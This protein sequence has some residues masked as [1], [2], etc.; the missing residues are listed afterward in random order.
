VGVMRSGSAT[1]KVPAPL[2]QIPLLVRP[3][4]ILVMGPFI[5]YSGDRA[6]PL[7]V[8]VY[9]GRSGEFVLYDDDGESRD[10]EGGA[11]EEITFSW[12]DER[13]VLTIGERQ[14]QGWEGMLESR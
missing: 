11:F 7:E 5:Q 9:P 8:R 1:V 3:G 4:G 14:G 12:D 6:D 2:E 10:Y 13:R